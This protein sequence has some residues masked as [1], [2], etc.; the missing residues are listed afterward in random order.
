MKKIKHWLITRVL[1]VWAKETLLRENERLTEENRELK[2]RINQL[3]SYIDGLE[4]GMKSQRRVVINNNLSE[5]RRIERK[6]DEQVA[7]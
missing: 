1:P 3:L 7:E 2:A 6:H 4:A 5:V